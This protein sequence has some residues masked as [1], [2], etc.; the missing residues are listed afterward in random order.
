[1]HEMFRTRPHRRPDQLHP[2][3]ALLRAL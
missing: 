3:C 1:M 2:L